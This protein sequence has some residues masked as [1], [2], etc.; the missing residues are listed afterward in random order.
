MVGSPQDIALA[1]PTPDSITNRNKNAAFRKCYASGQSECPETGRYTASSDLSLASGDLPSW[2]TFT[3]VSID[4]V[5]SSSTQKINID[6]SYA[7]IGTHI[8]SATYTPVHGQPL[9]SFIVATITIEC[10]VASFT[11]PISNPA[12]LTYTVFNDAL[13]FDMATLEYVQSPACNY[14]Y[15]VA[16]TWDSGTNTYIRGTS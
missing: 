4:E 14:A 3:P 9:T 12:D 7:E 5:Y 6:P 2:I 8:I 10:V 1:T 11:K 13:T 16:F 15:T